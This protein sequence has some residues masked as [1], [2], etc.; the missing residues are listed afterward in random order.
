MTEPQS[1]I[2]GQEYFEQHA[3][4]DLANLGFPF[5]RT[6]SREICNPAPIDTDADYVVLDLHDNGNFEKNG[7]AMTTDT[8]YEGGSDF[9]TYRRGEV[10]LIVV[11]SWPQFK[12]WKAATAAAK[13]MNI[14]DKQKRIALF[15]GVLYGNW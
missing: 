3:I 2:G 8:E 10:N 11:H 5:F 13:Q 1:T 15:Q 4:T 9:E 7:F 14:M 12:A 6:G